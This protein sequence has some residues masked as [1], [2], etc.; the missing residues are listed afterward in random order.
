MHP[1][2]KNEHL[3]Q[4]TEST[5]LIASI[6]SILAAFKSFP[7]AGNIDICPEAIGTVGT[8]LEKHACRINEHT[9]ELIKE[10]QSS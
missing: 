3:K 1:T 6:G 2:S 8:L 5:E 4:I 7:V 10:N 9:A